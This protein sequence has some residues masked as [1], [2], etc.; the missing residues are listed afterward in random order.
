MAKVDLGIPYAFSYRAGLGGIPSLFD[1]VLPALAGGR[2]RLTQVPSGY[3]LEPTTEEGPDVRGLHRR[4]PAWRD[5]EGR[6]LRKM[7]TDAVY[8]VTSTGVLCTCREKLPEGWSLEALPEFVPGTFA[9]PGRQTPWSILTPITPGGIRFSATW[10]EKLGIA[11]GTP[12]FVERHASGSG[13]TILS[14][15]T[16]NR[17]GRPLAWEGRVLRL[18]P[19]HMVGLTDEHTLYIVSVPGFGWV[20]RG[21][22][23]AAAPMQTHVARMP[24]ISQGAIVGKRVATISHMRGSI[25]FV[26]VPHACMQAAGFGEGTLLESKRM[27]C[28]AIR[29]ASS[30]TSTQK[31][32]WSRSGKYV[33]YRLGEKELAWC[34]PKEQIQFLVGKGVVYA[35]PAEVPNA[36][37]MLP[38]LVPPT[39][40]T[41][42]MAL[43]PD[44]EEFALPPEAFKL[45][46]FKPGS[47][48]RVR[49][50]K[51]YTELQLADDGPWTVGDENGPTVSLPR[52]LIYMV[53]GDTLRVEPRTPKVIRL[54]EPKAA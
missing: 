28:G 31:V 49:V 21:S 20:M 39:R 22:Q 17:G 53:Q 5:A 43:A 12:L 13:C 38:Y 36:I 6:N 25:R 1:A 24:D 16:L 7:D 47:R 19:E 4:A 15:T 3:F 41:V 42:V 29:I 9:H 27:A 26:D 40:E 51:T 11:P 45:S 32:R 14:V 23:R 54:Q 18:A 2:V 8:V 48:F 35:L 10:A 52:D 44:A 34:Q 46:K 50:H 37:P 33:S 30:E